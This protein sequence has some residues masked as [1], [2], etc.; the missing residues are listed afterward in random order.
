MLRPSLLR[1]AMETA[2]H[3]YLPLYVLFFL[4]FSLF[5][6]SLSECCENFGEALRMQI[7]TSWSCTPI[8]APLHSIF[9]S[10]PLAKGCA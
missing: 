3:F 4:S 8:S 5:L 9:V 2:F 10:F 1:C 7:K 6:C